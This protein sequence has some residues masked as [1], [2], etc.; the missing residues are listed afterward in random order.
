MKEVFQYIGLTFSI[1]I[2]YL[3]MFWIPFSTSRV[4]ILGADAVL[5]LLY[6]EL[7]DL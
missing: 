2:C 1:W 4:F 3:I 7:L 5:S 6:W